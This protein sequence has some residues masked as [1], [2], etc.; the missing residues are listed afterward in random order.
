MTVLLVGGDDDIMPRLHSDFRLPQVVAPFLVVSA[1]TWVFL[2]C[3]DIP[4]AH[5]MFGH[6]DKNGE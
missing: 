6:A 1:L 2:P 3:S 5:P 4:Q